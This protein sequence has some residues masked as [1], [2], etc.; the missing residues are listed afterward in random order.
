MFGDW[1]M[2]FKNVDA[3]DLA[4]FEGFSDLGSDAFWEKLNAGAIPEALDLL[5]S[6]YDG[7]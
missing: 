7:T 6:F 5:K 3:E 2:G 4:G 1:S